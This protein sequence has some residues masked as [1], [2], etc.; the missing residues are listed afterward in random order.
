MTDI[1]LEK[2]YSTFD[3]NAPTR[4]EEE[5][6]AKRPVII[7]LKNASFG[8]NKLDNGDESP[9]FVLNQVSGDIKKVLKTNAKSKIRKM[10]IVSILG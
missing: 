1:D 4:E 3:T 9:I 6:S 5:E 8:Y 2:Y 7:S 10:I